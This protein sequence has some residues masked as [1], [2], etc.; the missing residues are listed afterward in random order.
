MHTRWV[1]EKQAHDTECFP[2]VDLGDV[3][4]VD[5]DKEGQGPDL[6]EGR[7][8][9]KLAP[10]FGDVCER[11]HCNHMENRRWND[12]EVG[13][14]SA[15]SKTFQGQGQVLRRCGFGNLEHEPDD[16]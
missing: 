15:K 7:G 12:E 10:D 5:I 14:E 4:Q 3:D 9:G 11:K 6:S 13:F 16:I 1:T 8:K 2:L